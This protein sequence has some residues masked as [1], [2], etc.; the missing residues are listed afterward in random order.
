M[1]RK[2]AVNTFANSFTDRLPAVETY[3]WKSA[4]HW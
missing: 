1:R 3:K 2:P 4:E